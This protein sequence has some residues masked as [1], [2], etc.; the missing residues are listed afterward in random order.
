MRN[1][2]TK[3]NNNLR[4][5]RLERALKAGRVPYVRKPLPGLRKLLE[6][7][8]VDTSKYPFPEEHPS[9][10]PIVKKARRKATLERYKLRNNRKGAFKF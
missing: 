4:L 6:K 5:K 2:R 7:Y 10:R 8:D 3:H 9:M 1:S